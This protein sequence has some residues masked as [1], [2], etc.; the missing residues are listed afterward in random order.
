MEQ[1]PSE[2]VPEPQA[3]LTTR[4]ADLHPASWFA[5][6]WQPLYRIPD[7][8]LDAK[9]L[10]YYTFR[11]RGSD[12]RQTPAGVV[13]Q[14]PIAGLM[15]GALDAQPAAESCA[16]LENWA[17]VRPVDYSAQAHMQAAAH[18]AGVQRDLQVLHAAAQQ[19]SCS[20]GRD[21]EVRGAA[22]QRLE[23]EVHRDFQFLQRSRL[24]ASH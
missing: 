1:A 13:H 17:R 5:V 22:G 12:A 8:P 7:M 14:F 16:P 18:E 2:T 20:W 3:L 4:L 10:A 19:L 23:E 9:F 24:G 6:W 11:R 21:V 15:C